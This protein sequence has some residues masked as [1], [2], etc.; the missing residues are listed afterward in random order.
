[1]E[2]QVVVSIFPPGDHWQRKPADNDNKKNSTRRLWY[3]ALLRI[4]N[5]MSP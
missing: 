4:D 3:D 1:M 5:R 2:G